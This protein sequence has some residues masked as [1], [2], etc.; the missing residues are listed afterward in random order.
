MAITTKGG[1]LFITGAGTVQKF[2]DPVLAQAIYV[3]NSTVAAVDVNIIEGD[4]A[5]ATIMGV[6][7]PADTTLPLPLAR[8][9]LFASGIGVDASFVATVD[10]IVPF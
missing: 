8:P 1:T 9:K 4:A 2:S 6:T 10:L 7:V 5:G 3:R